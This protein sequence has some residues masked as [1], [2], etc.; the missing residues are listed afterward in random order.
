MIH[1]RNAILVLA[2]LVLVVAGCAKPATEVSAYVKPEVDFTQFD[3][4]QWQANRPETVM[5]QAQNDIMHRLIVQTLE[6]E[7]ARDGLEQ[8][9]NGDLTVTYRV[10]V[11]P[12]KSFWRTLFAAESITPGTYNQR[13]AEAQTGAADERNLQQGVLVIELIDQTGTV[14]W[15][16]RVSAIVSKA[17]PSHAV[18]AVRKVMA[19]YPPTM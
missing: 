4:Y 8:K 15:S 16:G 9:E 13:S 10:T 11:S 5:M 6:E 1:F 7:L 14:V 12:Q 18:Q 3:S 2:G 17:Q 19:D